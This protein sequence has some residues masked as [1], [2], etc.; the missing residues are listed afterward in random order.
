MRITAKASRIVAKLLR[1][2][3]GAAAVEFALVAV[4]FLALLFAILQTA[5]V[6]FATQTLDAAVQSSGRL[7]MTGQAQTAN[8]TAANFK[9]AVCNR[10]VSIFDCPG[11]MYV[12]VRTF[13]NFGSAS[14][15]APYN[16][17]G[18][19][20]TTAMSYSP[21]SAGSVVV[22]QLYYQLPIYMSLLNSAMSNQSGNNRLLIS[23][24]VFQNEPYQ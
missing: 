22:V 13:T 15:S 7:I 5:L 24:A 14:T 4:P 21:G 16:G 1:A 10:I 11:K 18:Q 20:D 17:S 3:D 23:T 2:D 6:F 9:T 12:N 8:Y 19:L